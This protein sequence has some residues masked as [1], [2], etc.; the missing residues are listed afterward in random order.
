MQFKAFS[1]MWVTSD[2]ERFKI[3]LIYYIIV[4]FD[5]IIV[6]AVKYLKQIIFRCP[7]ARNRPYG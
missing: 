3:Y 5:L 1:D 4:R 7:E 6:V 2:S